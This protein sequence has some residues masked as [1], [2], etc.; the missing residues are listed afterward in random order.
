MSI[1]TT[2][3]SAPGQPAIG[4]QIPMLGV[5]DGNGTDSGYDVVLPL[6]VAQCD[7]FIIYTNVTNVTFDYVVFTPPDDPDNPSKSAPFLRLNSLPN[8]TYFDWICN[9]PAGHSFHALAKHAQTYTVQNGS[10]SCLGD[11]PPFSDP[12]VTIT[13]SVFESFTRATPTYF[14]TTYQRPCVCL[15]AN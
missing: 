10:S 15:S 2:V 12:S 11:I 3:F 4:I 5:Q 14:S 6:T 13:T 1:L 8:G 7:H 9:I